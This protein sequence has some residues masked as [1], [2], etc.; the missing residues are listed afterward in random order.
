[1]EIAST[2]IAT[3][4]RELPDTEREPELYTNFTHVSDTFTIYHISYV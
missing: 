4:G 3:D 1:M 2:D